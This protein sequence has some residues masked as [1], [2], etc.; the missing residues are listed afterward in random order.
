MKLLLFVL[1]FY[2]KEI[3]GGSRICKEGEK[4]MTDFWKRI[5]LRSWIF[6]YISIRE[7]RYF[8]KKRSSKLLLFVLRF[9]VKEI[10]EESRICEGE[11]KI[12]TD[13]F[14]RILM[15]RIL[16]RSW[17]FLCISIREGRYTLERSSK[18]LLFVLR[19]YVKEILDGSRKEEKNNDGF[20]GGY[21]EFV[22]IE[23]WWKFLK[24][25]R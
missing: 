2:V 12:T 18:F 24:F 11:K 21:L 16:L 3:L 5:L 10:L 15:R 4:I 17:I 7:E 23:N 25:S 1:R 9:Y 6:L 20:L 8:R 19:F 14:E 22:K 13:S